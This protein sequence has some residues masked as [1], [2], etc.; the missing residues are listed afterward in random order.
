MLTVHSKNGDHR[1]KVEIA[2][3]PE[4]QERGLMFRKS[5]AGDCGM[6]FPYQPAQSVAFWMKNTLIPLDIIFIRAD[7]TIAR[8]SNAKAL[9]LT[10]VPSGEPITGVLEIRGGR[11]AELGIA[12]GDRAEW[13]Q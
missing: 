1:F 5:L 4:E 11:A 3:T 8:I 9:D 10:P 2:A 12:E 6:I 7:G 13:R